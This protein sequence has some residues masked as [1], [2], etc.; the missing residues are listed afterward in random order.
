MKQTAKNINL[1]LID[2]DPTARIKCTIANWTGLSFKLPRTSLELSKDRSDLKQ[3]GVYFLFGKS[4]VSDKA[5]AYIGQAG[6]RK[7][8]EGLLFRLQE[9]KNSASKDY[10]NEAIVF[11]TSNNSFGATEI[12][13]LENRFCMLAREANRYE[14][15]NLAEP[16]IGN[17]TEEK[18]AE[19]EE[20]IEYAKL[21]MAVLGHKVFIT[22]VENKSDPSINPYSNGNPTFKLISIAGIAYGQRTNEGFV[23][24]QGS[25]INS[26]TSASCPKHVKELRIKES[27][28]LEDYVTS[29]DLLFNSPSA[30]ACFVTGSSTN[31]NIAWR[32]DSDK[33]LKE[34]ES[35]EQ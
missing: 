29:K 27:D 22:Y 33:T 35:N 2:G 7:N 19:L 28:K 23:L 16:R 11:T 17:I 12:S 8:G 6:S 14:I 34:Y 3:S 5:V 30:A 31:G 15:K 18:Q 4:D 13:Y 32:T 25:H 20:Y 9:H 21:V 10:W 1:F 24:L 26:H